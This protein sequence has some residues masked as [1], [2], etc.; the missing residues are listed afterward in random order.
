MIQFLGLNLNAKTAEVV[1]IGRD[2]AVCAESD[3]PMVNVTLDAARGASTIP[4]TEWVRAGCYAIEQAYAKIP[5]KKRKVWGV[6]FAAPS[7]W[8]A[9]DHDYEPLSNLN[10]VTGR[11]VS[12]DFGAWCLA[13]T[14]LVEK[15]AVILTPKD[16]FRFAI[17]GGLATDA[18]TLR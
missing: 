6:A 15:T 7:G 9:L 8:I 16:F 1:I 4:P 14:R 13:N 3:T 17:S 11:R 10:I 5:A 12:E 18:S 2:A